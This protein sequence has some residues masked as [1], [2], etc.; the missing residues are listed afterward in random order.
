MDIAFGAGLLIGLSLL[1]VVSAALFLLFLRIFRGDAPANGQCGKCGYSVEG[2]TQ[3]NCPECGADL[4]QVGIKTA[5]S[6]SGVLPALLAAVV[7][8]GLL[9]CV[10]CAG[11]WLVRSQPAMTPATPAPV[12]VVPA[13]APAPT[14]PS[15]PPLPTQPESE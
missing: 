14:S 15:T 6:Q 5:P 3:L 7:T 1:L 4:R 11:L 10:G 9:S 8:L 2:L 13:P 12:R